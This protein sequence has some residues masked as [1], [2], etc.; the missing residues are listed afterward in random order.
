MPLSENPLKNKYLPNPGT[1]TNTGPKATPCPC[2]TG[3]NNGLSV[4]YY[5]KPS[6]CPSGYTCNNLLL[7]VKGYNK[8]GKWTPIPQTWPANYN[9]AN[10]CEVASNDHDNYVYSLQNETVSGKKVDMN[11][12]CIKNLSAYNKLS[13]DQKKDFEQLTE[14]QASLLFPGYQCCK[15]LQQKKESKQISNGDSLQFNRTLQHVGDICDAAFNKYSDK[16]KEKASQLGIKLSG[17]DVKQSSTHT[18][19][20]KQTSSPNKNII[21]D[22]NGKQ[23]WQ[24]FNKQNKDGHSALNQTYLNPIMSKDTS[25]VYTYDISED[26]D[27]NSKTV[28]D[29]YGFCVGHEYKKDTG[30][31]EALRGQPVGKQASKDGSKVYINPPFLTCQSPKKNEKPESGKVNITENGQQKSVDYT[32]KQIQ[33]PGGVCVKSNILETVVNEPVMFYG[34]GSIILV[35]LIV[36]AIIIITNK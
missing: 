12:P 7:W 10:I 15:S 3:N 28:S 22:D 23:T 14:M 6:P 20:G 4:D 17:P 24:D 2:Y 25:D 26:I 33:T 29:Y 32:C 11:D 31:Y 21:S 9:G 8:N 34:I 36:V 1:C 19:N 5:G 18:I 13:D 27:A 35:I 16:L 30:G